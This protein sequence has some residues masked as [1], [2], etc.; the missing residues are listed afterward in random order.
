MF[1]TRILRLSDSKIMFV[2]KDGF[3]CEQRGV[4]QRI[5]LILLL[6]SQESPT[7]TLTP[8]GVCTACPGFLSRQ[9]RKLGRTESRKSRLD[10]FWA[11]GSEARSLVGPESESTCRHLP[12]CDWTTWSSTL[13]VLLSDEQVNHSLARWPLSHFRAQGGWHIWGFEGTRKIYNPSRT[14]G[15]NEINKLLQ[16]KTT[17]TTAG[18]PNWA[19]ILSAAQPKPWITL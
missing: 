15:R 6:T 7:P 18:W 1:A 2:W 10:V 14:S 5:V 12:C 11:G 9:P 16:R 13:W 3:W 19:G 8:F 4:F 17:M